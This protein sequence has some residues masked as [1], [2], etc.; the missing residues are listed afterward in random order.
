[1]VAVPL[2]YH[3]NVLLQISSSFY[4]APNPFVQSMSTDKQ[5]E[6]TVDNIEL[7]TACDATST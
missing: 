1:M 6:V 5:Q 2:Q 7:I 3:L 4:S